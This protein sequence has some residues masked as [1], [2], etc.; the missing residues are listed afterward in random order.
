MAGVI[1]NRKIIILLYIF[2]VLL[3]ILELEAVVLVLIG[4]MEKR[5]KGSLVK[6]DNVW[7]R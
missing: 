4:K 1:K 2:I 7:A 3:I 6:T 5:L